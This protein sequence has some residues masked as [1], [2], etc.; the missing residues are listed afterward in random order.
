VVA[1]QYGKDH[2]GTL[3]HESIMATR[4]TI[5]PQTAI[6]IIRSYSQPLRQLLASCEDLA[7]RQAPGIIAA[8][9]DQSTLALTRE[10]DRL[11]ALALVNPNVRD[12]EI[13]FM[14]LQREA[15][16]VALDSATL[17]LDALRVAVAT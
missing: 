15:L 10:V 12:E 6:K 16:V 5:P 14:E 9:R 7:N 3:T 11:K 13:E 1:D 4:E 17:R 8:A 2:S